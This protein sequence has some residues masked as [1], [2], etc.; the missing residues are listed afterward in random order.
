MNWNGDLDVEFF[1]ELDD[2]NIALALADPEAHKN[3]EGDVVF[4]GQG[5]CANRYY[6][7][8]RKGKSKIPGSD[9]K[10]GP[11]NGP[12]C[13][14]CWAFQ[15]LHP[16]ENEFAHLAMHEAEL[17][18]V[19]N[20]PERRL[21]NVV[22]NVRQQV[23]DGELYQ[24]ETPRYPEQMIEETVDILVENTYPANP[25]EVVN[26]CMRT[27]GILDQPNMVKKVKIL[28]TSGYNG[29]P[30]SEKKKKA[31]NRMTSVVKMIG[32]NVDGWKCRG[33]GPLQRCGESLEDNSKGFQKLHCGCAERLSVGLFTI[34]KD[35]QCDDETRPTKAAHARMMVENEKDN[36]AR[37]G[38]KLAK[39]FRYGSATVSD[40][41]VWL[42][43]CHIL[44]V[45]GGS[46]NHGM[47][48]L[49]IGGDEKRKVLEERILSGRVAVV[50][51]SAGAMMW[52][53]RLDSNRDE[54]Q[55]LLGDDAAGIGLFADLT[56]VPHTDKERLEHHHRQNRVTTQYPLVFDPAGELPNRV[57][58]LVDNMGLLRVGTDMSYV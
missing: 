52:G 49:R 16:I 25:H 4:R 43:Q 29:N 1:G 48:I 20:G 19:A 46:V 40:L 35:R 17:F 41:K 3:R 30:W 37:S 15:D 51:N 54:D 11:T 2:P 26:D 36:I 14:T 18:R 39:D 56:I 23:G 50:G 58:P 8:I 44:W 34:H 28:A 31:D 33:Q 24:P 45:M 9:G 6:C 21:A 5:E 55:M 7:G 42:D 38:F 12:Q 22:A 27:G 53:L 10:C 47:H 32:R 13:E 57:A